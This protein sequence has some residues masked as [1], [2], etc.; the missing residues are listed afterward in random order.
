MP[1]KS[2][3]LICFREDENPFDRFA[4]KTVTDNGNIVGHL[5]REIS[6]IT[7]FL[8]DRGA[9]VQLTLTSTHYRRSQ[10]VQGGLEIA[11]EVV[12]RMPATIKNHMIN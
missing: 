8:L 4:I 10:L 6:R 11:S 2:E 7:K 5:P 1:T 3:K 12:A 9:V